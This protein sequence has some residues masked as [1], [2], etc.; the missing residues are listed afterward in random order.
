MNHTRHKKIYWTSLGFAVVLVAGIG[1]TAA[2]EGLE[3]G[4]HG[5]VRL[6]TGWNRG[7]GGAQA[8]FGLE[9]VPKY[10]LGNE[11]DFNSD[12][13]YGSELMKFSNGVSL[14]GL[15][16]IHAFTPTPH[17][18][19][20]SV[21]M[22]QAFVEAKG[23]GFLRGGTAWIGRRY[24]NRP[25]IHVLDFKYVVMDGEGLGVDSIPLGPGKFSYAIFRNDVDKSQSATR[26]G[27]IYQD[28]PVNTNGTL[29]IDATIIRADDSSA[30]VERH[31]G[32]ALS[33]A[34]KQSKF[35]GGDNILA[36]QYGVGPGINIG[37]TG[38]LSLGATYHRT[39]IADQ[40]IW[41]A[42]PRLI[43][44]A[45]VVVQRDRGPVGTQTWT[46]VG[47]RPVYILNE[48]IKLQ[49]D[50][51]HDRI[52]PADGGPVQRLTKV[53]FAPTLTAGKDFFKRPELRLFVTYARWNDAAQAAATLDS[54][55]SRTG[56]FGGST[57]GVSYGI[58]FEHWF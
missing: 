29:K 1:G 16:M 38:D 56:V 33:L 39:R 58:H 8:C 6:G 28:L 9:G 43:G 26:H 50:V 45:D 40:L 32:W 46:S 34:H 12:I 49:L 24:Y 11:C 47:V 17:P 2:G 22:I 4:F 20:S 18:F 5:Y 54:T 23:I 27:F 52:S 13:G 31:N 14:S 3:E 37:G 55:L 53:T 57:S 7:E 30:T 15:A 19:D 21:R 48:H 10:R 25:D 35:L 41:Q 44:S 42:A 36:L 51:G